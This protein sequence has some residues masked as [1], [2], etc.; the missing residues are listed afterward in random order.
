MVETA[1]LYIIPL[2]TE[3]LDLYLQAGNRFEEAF[4]LARTNRVVAPE[5]QKMVRAVTLPNM[6]NAT[7]DNYLFYTFWLVVEKSSRTVVAEL[8]FKGEPN[9]KGEVEIGYG[10]MPKRQREGFM[11][12]AVAGIIDWARKRADVHSIL[13]ETDQENSASIKVLRRNGFAQCDKKENM[14]WWKISVLHQNAGFTPV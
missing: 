10:T 5:V 9:S 2:T 8:G 1:R 14:L 13:A 4:A 11:T 7:A 12:E 6:Q 3:A